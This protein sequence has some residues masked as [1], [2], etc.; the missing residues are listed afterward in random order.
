LY[1]LFIEITMARTQLRCIIMS[2]FTFIIAL[3]Q[4]NLIQMYIQKKELKIHIHV[5][6]NPCKQINELY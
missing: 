3:L 2:Y 4:G 6:Y 1:E 5:D